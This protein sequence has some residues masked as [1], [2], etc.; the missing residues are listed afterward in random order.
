M[1]KPR[2]DAVKRFFKRL[3][4]SGLTKTLSLPSF[5]AAAVGLTRARGKGFFSNNA[6]DGP[7]PKDFDMSKII[8][9]LPKYDPKNFG[10]FKLKFLISLPLELSKLFNEKMPH[11]DVYQLSTPHKTPAE[12]AD[13]RLKYDRFNRTAYQ[14][15]CKVVEND[16]EAN[17]LVL[18][19]LYSDDT[20][21][22]E[23][24]K[25]LNDK[26]TIV[27]NTE[28]FNTI[29]KVLHL[30]QEETETT[31]QYKIREQKLQNFISSQ[32]ISL[33]DIRLSVWI[34]GLKPKYKSVVEG[35]L[36]SGH[37]A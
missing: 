22:L 33:T 4:L 17:A 32:Q 2:L 7:N 10:E 34:N 31:E 1:C 11:P 24:W 16:I 9:I 23:A 37:V 5:T 29:L 28:K 36:T 3:S 14:I 25:A 21:G 27:S 12:H 19:P 8:P 13:Y 30:K 20:D 15:L 26:Y 6:G 18:D 35:L